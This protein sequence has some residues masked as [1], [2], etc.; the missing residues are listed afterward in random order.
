MARPGDGEVLKKQH[1]VAEVAEAEPEESPRERQRRERREKR[2]EKL[3]KLTSRLGKTAGVR[4][5][6]VCGIHDYAP[7]TTEIDYRFV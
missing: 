3:L 4:H 7:G 1:G 2:E 5:T 6:E